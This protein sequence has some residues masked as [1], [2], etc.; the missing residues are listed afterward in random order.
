MMHLLLLGAA[1]LLSVLLVVLHLGIIWMGAP[2]Y[3]YFGAGEAMARLAEQG[4]HIPG[5]VTLAATALFALAALY[6]LSAA[7]WAPRLP[8]LRHGLAC[9]AAVYTLRGSLL[10][11]QL[12]RRGSM[13]LPVRELV[14]S[15]VSLT[16]GLVY[17]AA[18]ASVWGKLR[19]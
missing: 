1:S 17:V 6:P 15:A 3:R 5:L 18:L 2:A 14:F 4:S 10:V 9:I 12:A 13:E 11:L 8:F 16:V 7:G 19:S